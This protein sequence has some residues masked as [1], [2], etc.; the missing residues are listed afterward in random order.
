MTDGG[1]FV[2]QRHQPPIPLERPR[3]LIL[4]LPPLRSNVNLAR[5]I[6]LAGC[7]GLQRVIACGHGRIDEK[8]ARDALQQVSLERHRSLAPVLKQLRE[9]DY[10][11]V[12]LEQTSGSECLYQYRF[13]R[14]A[15]LVV[16]H[17]RLGLEEEVLRLLDDVVEI[18]VYGVPYSHNVATATAMALYEYC[19]Q[20][21]TG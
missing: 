2:H 17:E 21:P 18:P 11:L 8:I 19:R 7:C 10:H 6:R 16:G 1:R 12:G 20:Y 13:P 14:R 3:E 5:I 9:A 15:V 4:A